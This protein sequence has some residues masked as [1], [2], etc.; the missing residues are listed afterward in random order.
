MKV[1][2]KPEWLKSISDRAK[3]SLSNTM[4]RVTKGT[5][6][7]IVHPGLENIS[8]NR[9]SDR[10]ERILHA[11][12]IT[13]ELRK[14][15]D[16]NQ[17]KLGPRSIAKPWDERKESLYAYFR[18]ISDLNPGSFG[19]ND[20]VL[21]PA[22]MT[23]VIGNL[24]K[25]SSSGLPYMSKKGLVLQE[26]IRD[27]DKLSGMY[28]CVLFTRT[29]EQGKTRNVWGYPITETIAEQ[30]YHIP[31]LEVEKR[32]AWRAALLG[33]D[34]V[35]EAVSNMLLKKTD[36]EVIY[37]VDFSSYDASISPRH[38]YAAF[39]YIASHFQ[40]A[41]KPA[42]Y[43][44]YRTFVSIPIWTPEGE[45]SGPHG[46]PSG[47]SF[48]NTIDSL[49][50]HSVSE[51]ASQNLECQIQGDDG[52][53]R[54]PKYMRDSFANRFKTAGLQINEDKSE[55]FDSSTPQGVYLQRYYH[56]MY[57][58]EKTG[59][60]GGVYSLY[61][62]INRIKYL[63]R[64]VTDVGSRKDSVITGEDYFSLRTIMILENCKHHPGFRDFVKLVQS[65]DETG[66]RFNKQALM[67]FQMMHTAKL[68]A[69]TANEE[70]ATGIHKFETLKVLNE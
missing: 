50:Q 70:F 18:G 30:R 67:P 39:S 12:P 47:S 45:I 16:S 53:Y 66:L 24:V 62:A 41:A 14:I 28:P 54:I 61:R 51:S 3:L 7:V 60:L 69:S 36:D 31:W 29:Q 40:Q 27:Y 19:S 44:L 42:L 6:N 25:S 63:E 49:V 32:L 5:D 65:L 59:G 68:R 33:P 9:L 57:R 48:T 10:I 58:S 37:C 4:N 2:A 1:N 22:N 43:D 15:E 8:V 56:P 34:L 46:V 13:P 17:S 55:V 20:G 38:A 11:H 21:R 35:D 64:W 26:A 23:T 52:I